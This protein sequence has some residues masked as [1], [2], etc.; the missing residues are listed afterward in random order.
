MTT[1]IVKNQAEWDALPV[2]F[3]EFKDFTV[4]EIRGDYWNPITVRKVPAN[5]RVV[6]WGSSRVVQSTACTGISG[7][8][9]RTH[10]GKGSGAHVAGAQ[11]HPRK[12]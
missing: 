7:T 8:M 3:N 1:I 10:R 11:R 12:R 6:A 5:A 9:S 2:E 4:I